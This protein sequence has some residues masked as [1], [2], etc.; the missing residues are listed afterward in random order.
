MISRY[1]RLSANV[2]SLYH[3]YSINIRCPGG[4]IVPYNGTLN[5]ATERCETDQALT[6]QRVWL[7]LEV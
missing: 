7:Q 4:Y 1:P 3:T 5:T 2:I 6:D